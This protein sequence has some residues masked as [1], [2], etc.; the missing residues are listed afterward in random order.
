MV[1]WRRAGMDAGIQREWILVDNA[2]NIL[3]DTFGEVTE[4]K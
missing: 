1:G 4:I 3:V 2:P